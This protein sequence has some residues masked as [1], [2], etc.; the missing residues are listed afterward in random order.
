[1]KRYVLIALVLLAVIVTSACSAR[2]PTQAEIER[3]QIALERE[4]EQ[5]EQKREQHAAWMEFWQ[6]VRPWLEGIVILAVFAIAGIA[7][8]CAFEWVGAKAI[9]WRQ[10]QVEAGKEVIYTPTRD[11]V[12]MPQ[13]LLRPFAILTRGKEHAPE[14]AADEKA[15]LAVTMAQQAVAA[16]AVESPMVGYQAPGAVLPANTQPL[17]IVEPEKL[18]PW[19]DDIRGQLAAGDVIDA[20]EVDTG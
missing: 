6:T 1:M 13:R 20:V 17:H 11:K 18:T 3:Q 10:V 12:L 15:Q 19:V 8:W 16:K 5:L 4:R 2:E 14:M 9:Q 7:V